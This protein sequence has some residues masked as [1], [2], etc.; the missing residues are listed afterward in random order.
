MSATL[1]PECAQ[2]KHIN[3]DGRALDSDTDEIGA[4]GCEC[5]VSA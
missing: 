2:G 3:C 5:G 4:C 1:C